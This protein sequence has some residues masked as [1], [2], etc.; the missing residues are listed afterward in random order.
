MAQITFKGS[1]INTEGNLPEVGSTAPN[2]K[3]TASDL[4]EKSLSDYAGKN[5]VLNIFPSVDT[6]VC[7]QSVRT[8]NKEV[9]SVDNTVV[10]CISKDLP[11]ALNRFCAAEGLNNVATLSDFKNNDFDKAYGVKMTDGPLNGLLSRAVVVINPEGKVV[12]NEQVPEITQEPDYNHAI[13]AL[14]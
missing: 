7:A 5:V 11:F 14:K 12:Y 10:L 4:S 2:F 3:L 6:G 13:N 8:F 9:S 1:P